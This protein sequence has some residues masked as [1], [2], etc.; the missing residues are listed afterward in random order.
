MV[1]KPEIIITAAKWWVSLV[2][3]G[4]TFQS[5]LEDEIAKYLA[6]KP[7]DIERP[8]FGEALRVIYV[9]YSPNTTLAKAA[10]RGGVDLNLFPWK[11]TMWLN[12]NGILVRV[13]AYGEVQEIP[14]I[15]R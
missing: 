5:A 9:E 4:D 15:R 10:E 1:G 13:G 6:D 12:P 14:I 3:G 7:W 2:N 8:L 11:T